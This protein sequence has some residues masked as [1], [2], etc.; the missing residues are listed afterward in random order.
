MKLKEKYE[1]VI[2]AYLIL[3]CKKHELEF[4]DI[5]WMCGVGTFFNVTDY[6]IGFS[7]VKYDI[8]NKI[9]SSKFFDW[10][11]YSIESGMKD[12]PFD[13]YEKYLKK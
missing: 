10:Y 13:N 8:D 1:S 7:D 5:D 3:F 2:N 12:E 6:Y 11:D 4:N 9:E